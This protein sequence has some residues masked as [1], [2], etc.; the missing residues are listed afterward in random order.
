[1]TRMSRGTRVRLIALVSVV[2]VVAGGGGAAA[3][4]SGQAQLQAQAGTAT[5]GVR[6]AVLPT[7]T[8]SPLI[9]TYTAGH[10]RSAGALQIQNAGSRSATLEVAVSAESPSVAGLPASIGV[11]MAP[12]ATEAACT[13][14]A[15][16]ASPTTGQLSTAAS[17]TFT[18]TIAAGASVVVCVQTTLPAQSQASFA[19][20]QVTLVLA[21]SLRY[22]AAAAWT[23]AAPVAR[24]TQL[25]DAGAAVLLP[26]GLYDIGLGGKGCVQPGGAGIERH[27]GCDS[28]TWSIV[29]A[30]GT[31]AIVAG[32]GDRA[33]QRWTAIGTALQLQPASADPSQQW[34]ISGPVAGGY[35]LESVGFPGQ[36]ATVLG[37]GRE[38]VSLQPCTEASAAQTFSLQSASGS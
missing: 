18:G 9:A 27:P 17:I 10:T 13:A 28:F 20:G 24:A 22:A 36:C 37:T 34:R 1:M 21:P 5:T 12:V 35:R 25:V 38:A 14:Q 26:D 11:A 8:T 15:T 3:Y 31:I 19:D 6:A 30:S 33:G 2:L 4:W 16:L 32:E 7:A 29:N 23:V